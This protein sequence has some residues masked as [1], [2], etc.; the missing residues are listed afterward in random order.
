MEALLER[1]VINDMSALQDTWV[2]LFGHRG[3]GPLKKTVI[4]E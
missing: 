2:Y 1:G 3:P 4:L